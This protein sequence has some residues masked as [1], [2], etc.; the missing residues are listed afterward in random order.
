[1]PAVLARRPARALIA[2]AVVCVATLSP[3]VVATPRAHAALPSSVGPAGPLQPPVGAL[4]PDGARGTGDR[5]LGLVLPSGPRVTPSLS[6]P[7]STSADAMAGTTGLPESVDLSAN[8]P[9][10]SDQGGTQ[11]C[12]SWVVAYDLRGWY[13]RRDGYYPAGGPNGTG[14]FA[15]MY[16]YNQATGGHDAGSSFN[17]NLDIMAAQG[18]DT[19][20][21]YVPQGDID[22]AD[23]PSGA[24]RANAATYRIAGYTVLFQ[25]ANQGPAARQAIETSIANGE[26]VGLGIPIYDN[27]WNAGSSSYYVDG[28]PEPY[29]GNHAVFA[30]KY[31][32]NGVWVENSWGTWWGLNGW[33]ELSWAFVDQYVWQAV[34]MQPLV[35]TG[36]ATPAPPTATNTA[37]SAPPT[38][39]TTAT[40]VPPTATTTATLVPPTAT[41]TATPGRPT[42]TKANTPTNTATPAPPTVTK[43]NTATNTPTATSTNT[44]TPVLPTATNTAT[45]APPTAT[46]TNVPTNTTAPPTPTNT[47][48]PPTP[49]ST[50]TA[51]PAP[52]A[53]TNTAT[54]VPSGAAITATPVLPTVPPRPTIMNA[55]VTA[56]ATPRMG[57]TASGTR[58]GSIATGGAASSYPFTPGMSGSA[59]IGM[60]PTRTTNDYD[61][62]VYDR[63]STLLAA[64]DTPSSCE[65]ATFDVT[66]GHTYTVNT[67]SYTGS[68]TYRWAWSVGN[69]PVVWHVSG[70]IRASGGNQYLSIPTLSAGPMALSLCGRS[71]AHDNLYLKDAGYHTLASATAQSACQ[72]LSYASRARG[73]YHVDVVAAGGTGAWSGI[74]ST[75]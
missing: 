43:A 74:F 44:A 21:D 5:G 66:A 45:L 41:T 11:S 4:R 70:T 50:N 3:N 25:G 51:T 30:V 37:T 17:G 54:P 13:A 9:P 33:V 38:A 58:S 52:P 55:T 36:A 28:A 67:V 14:S 23:A 53:A 75:R 34:T 19:R 20:A 32:A 6:R 18:V 24:Q 29:Y 7:G 39:T 26:P 71:G 63:S 31:D 47:A 40:L 61:L 62:Y 57:G 48:A 15:P 46:K 73:L 35:S 59:T 1:M 2:L 8:A 10:V 49:T 65:W 12:V 27:F 72:S 68:G 56:T 69:A 22:Y 16:L 64:S 60:C 42:A